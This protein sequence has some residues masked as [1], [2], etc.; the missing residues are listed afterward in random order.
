MIGHLQKIGGDVDPNFGWGLPRLL[1]WYR[2]ISALECTSHW[3][4][5]AVDISGLQNHAKP[6]NCIGSLELNT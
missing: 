3:Q 4:Q 5:L 6:Q 1:I 2:L